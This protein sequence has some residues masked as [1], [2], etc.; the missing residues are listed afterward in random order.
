M[1]DR[2]QVD[3]DSRSQLVEHSRLLGLKLFS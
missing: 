3:P 1:L 2:A